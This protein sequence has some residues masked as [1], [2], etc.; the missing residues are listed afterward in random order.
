MA[1]ER[2]VDRLDWAR[3]RKWVGVSGGGAQVGGS[4]E[5]SW[6]GEILGEAPGRGW[7]EGRI[8][9]SSTGERKNSSRGAWSESGAADIRRLVRADR[10]KL[11]A[12]GSSWLLG[13]LAEAARFIGNSNDWGQGRNEGVGDSAAMSKKRVSGARGR[14]SPHI[15]TKGRRP[16]RG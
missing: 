2:S 9:R 11:E 5:C 10:A 15:H 3:G 7:G 8:R 16:T 14:E 1:R 13:R 6:I 4:R 12:S